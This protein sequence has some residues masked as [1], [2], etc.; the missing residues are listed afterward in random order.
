MQLRGP[1]LKGKKAFTCLS[2]SVLVSNR[3]GSNFSGL[4]KYFSLLCMCKRLKFTNDPAGNTY[5]P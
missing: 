1:A 3:I 5:P 2:L 4:G